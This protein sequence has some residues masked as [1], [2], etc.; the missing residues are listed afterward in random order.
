MDKNV[1]IGAMT[2]LITPFKNG[3]LDEQTYIKL[4]QRQ[5]AHGID[6]V[7]P[8]GTTGESATLTHNEHKTCIELAVQTCKNTKVKVLAGAGSNA[9]H[10][11]E[12]LAKFAQEQGAEQDFLNII[13]LLQRVWIFQC[14]CIMF[15]AGQLVKLLQIQQLSFL[16]SVKIFMGLKKRVEV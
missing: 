8:V 16:G 10:E 14:F 9:T 1:I 12:D 3:K 11:A 13:R 5:I 6:A 2:A 4:I 7:I 15:R